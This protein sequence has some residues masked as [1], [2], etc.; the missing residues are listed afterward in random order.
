MNSLALGWGQA[1][2]P[3]EALGGEG[4]SW[5]YCWNYFSLLGKAAFPVSK[6]PSQ[7]ELKGKKP[8]AMG[9]DG[10]W[11]LGI[12]PCMVMERCLGERAGRA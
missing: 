4:G 5:V 1:R 6:S 2:C 3:G 12:V 9:W 10:W 11:L 8:L 7:L